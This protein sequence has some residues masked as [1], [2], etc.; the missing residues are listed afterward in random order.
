MTATITID[1][2]RYADPGSDFLLRSH[3]LHPHEGIA[4]I[5]MIRAQKENIMSVV[6]D[7]LLESISST[8]W[9]YNE[10]DT[11]FSYV[12]ERY[13]HFLSQLALD[14]S[15]TVEALF[16]VQRDSHLIVS[17]LGSMKA[18]MREYDGTLSQIQENTDNYHRFELISSGDITT[19]SA[20]FL[21]SE[22]IAAHVG[23]DFYSDIT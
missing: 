5:C 17:T 20:V 16:A 19:G 10:E 14:D 7:H 9:R 6:E 18:M 23:E 21:S 8:E 4:I 22:D 15:M 12:T 3:I 11:D 1:I 13:N 2:V